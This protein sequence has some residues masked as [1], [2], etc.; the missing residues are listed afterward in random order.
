MAV[1]PQSV[2]VLWVFL[3]FVVERIVEVVL[4]VFPSLDKKKFLGVETPLLLSF[5]FSLITAVGANLNFFDLF[6]ICFRWYFVGYI[7]S[8]LT[9]TG[10]SNLLHDIVEWVRT[11]KELTCARF[12]NVNYTD[13]LPRKSDAEAK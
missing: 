12:R 1:P 2:L 9:M 5:V 7:F 13:L 3:A 10:G 8:A 6:G 11:G 4:K